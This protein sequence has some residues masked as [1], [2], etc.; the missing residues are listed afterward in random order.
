[1]F[2]K[3]S[4]GLSS[5][6]GVVRKGA[7]G[8]LATSKWLKSWTI[9]PDDYL[10]TP[11]VLANSFPKSGTHLLFQIVDGLPNL[12]NYGSFLASMTSSFR[13]RER[14][15]ENASHFISRFAPGEIVRGHL[16]YHL[17]NAA[18]LRAK[19]VV[20]YFAF[21][22]PRDVVV[23][24][25]HY[26]RE[27][28]PWHRLAPYFRKVASIDEAIMLSITGF[29]PPVSE[30][31]YPNIAARFA[32]YAGWLGHDECLAV[33]F[34]D[35]ASESRPAVIRRMAEFYAAHC[36]SRIDIEACIAAMTA[37]IAPERSH[38][39]RSGKKA[40]WRKEF[41]AKHRRVFDQLAGKLLLDLG[42]E[43][44]HDW[45]QSPAVHSM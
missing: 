16:F 31:D 6:Y 35:L 1:M 15:S 41:T 12:T 3:L 14:S 44:N 26:L 30:I 24:E 34:E 17:Q 38:T 9:D 37:S 7:I 8:V 10:A 28:N 33:R 36:R 23:S 2:S 40:G 21:R 42:Y 20:H 4:R 32:R 22:D 25:A 5:K 27:M 29:D 45:V 43:S 39:F 13:F 18:D 11:P 19:N